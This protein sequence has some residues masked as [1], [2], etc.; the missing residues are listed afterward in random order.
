MA[1][2]VGET[3]LEMVIVAIPFGTT[4][5]NVITHFTVMLYDFLPIR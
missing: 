3:R 4:N 1:G 2:C 5:G